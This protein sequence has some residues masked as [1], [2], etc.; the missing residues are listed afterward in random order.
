MGATMLKGPRENTDDIIL[1][2]W[3]VQMKGGVH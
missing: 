3:F 1:C 2:M